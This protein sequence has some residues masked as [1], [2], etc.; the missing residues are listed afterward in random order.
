MQPAEHVTIDTPEQIALELQV[1][2]IGSRFLAIA[3]DTVLQLLLYVSVFMA[4]SLASVPDF[5]RT[6]FVG[7][8]GPFVRVEALFDDQALLLEAEIP[9]EDFAELS[10]A[11]GERVRP[12]FRRARLFARQPGQFDLNAEQASLLSSNL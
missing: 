7:V 4:L 8:A 1:A 11:I 9:R 10:L 3:V 6:S 2:G 12:H 5:L